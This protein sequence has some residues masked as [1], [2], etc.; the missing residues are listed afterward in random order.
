LTDC[1]CLSISSPL[2]VIPVHKSKL[3]DFSQVPTSTIEWYVLSW[4]VFILIEFVVI[5]RIATKLCHLSQVS[6]REIFENLRKII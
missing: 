6:N 3:L 4:H 5:V 1:W 2:L